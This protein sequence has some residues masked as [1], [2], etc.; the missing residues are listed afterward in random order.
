MARLEYKQIECE[1]KGFK[2]NGLGTF[3]N[4]V[5]IN[6]NC[7]CCDK[8]EIE[9][10]QAEICNCGKGIECTS[11]K[12]DGCS[13][14]EDIKYRMKGAYNKTDMFYKTKIKDQFV[15]LEKK[16]YFIVIKVKNFDITTSSDVYASV[17]AIAHPRGFNAASSK[18]YDTEYLDDGK[19]EI[20]R[21]GSHSL[22]RPEQRLR[23]MR[24]KTSCFDYIQDR[25]DVKMNE[26]KNTTDGVWNTLGEV[27][28][29]ACAPYQLFGNPR[30]H[31]YVNLDVV[32]RIWDA[33]NK[34]YYP[35]GH[36]LSNSLATFKDTDGEI[37]IEV[38]GNPQRTKM[39]GHFEI[40]KDMSITGYTNYNSSR[41]KYN[42]SL[43]IPMTNR[44]Q[45]YGQWELRDIILNG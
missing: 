7:N 33:D 15:Q 2:C 18:P 16:D 30:Q 43:K 40:G 3:N 35:S 12:G 13:C 1:C 23:K 20:V 29:R 21:L 28:V 10:P 39:V 25:F 34:T 42:D 37:K 8:T 41:T 31:A 4:N 5:L 14:C 26:Y 11:L 38:Y 27:S 24:N 22:T 44:K 9:I 17:L 45:V 6:S 32:V 36:T 19:P